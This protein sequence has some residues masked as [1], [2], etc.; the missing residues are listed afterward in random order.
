MKQGQSYFQQDD[1]VSHFQNYWMLM[2][3]VQKY[4]NQ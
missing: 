3:Q 2:M 4:Q 1:E